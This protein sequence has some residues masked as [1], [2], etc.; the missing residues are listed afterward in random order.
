MPGYV[1]K[2]LKKFKHPKP[3]KPQHA[4][5]SWTTPKYGQKR[6]YAKVEPILPVLLDKLTNIIQQKV[7]SILYYSRAIET[8]ALPALT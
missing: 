4:P 6:Q 5:H 8:P 2:M 3:N 1:Q 7:G